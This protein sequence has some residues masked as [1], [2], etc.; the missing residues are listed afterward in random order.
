VLKKEGKYKILKKTTHPIH[1]V[2][3]SLKKV[4]EKEGKA[5]IEKCN[6]PTPQV[7]QFLS[8]ST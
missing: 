1:K 2:H 4:L 8:K 7:P 3:S 6:H 5:K